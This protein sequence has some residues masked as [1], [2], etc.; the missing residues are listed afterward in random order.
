MA[1]R[2]RVRPPHSPSTIVAIEPPRPL[3]ARRAEAS[4]WATLL[5]VAAV[6]LATMDDRHVGMAADE[7]QMIWTAVAIAETGQ[8]AQ[9]R[10]R[11]FTFV[12][13]AGE[14]VSR[15]G[16]GMT[17]LQVPAAL[18]APAV[19]R[20]MGAGASQP[21]FLIVPF[22]LVLGGAAAAG[23]AC[24][25]LGGRASTAVLLASI[26]SPLASYAATG[27]S[28]PLQAAALTSAFALAL[29]SAASSDSG[30]SLRLAV[31]AGA[32][33][34][35]AVLAKSALVVVAPLVVVPVIVSVSDGCRARR[36]VAAV[37]GFLPPM[38]LWAV[39]D[40]ARF[41]SLL[42]AYPGETF[43]HPVWDGAW[44]LLVGPNQGLAWFFPA[45]LVV[46]WL[47]V[48]RFRAGERAALVPLGGALLPAAALFVLTASWWAWHGVWGWGPRLLMPAI[49]PLAAAAGAEMAAWPAWG[50]RAL[51]GLSIVLN[52]PGLV[53]HPTPVASYVSNLTWPVATPE[54]AR[55]L[56]GYAVRHESDGTVRVSPDHVLATM[57]QASPFVVFPWFFA[58]NWAD[59]AADAARSLESPP[60]SGAR[61]DLTPAERPLSEV[62]LRQITGFPRARFWGRGFAPTPADATRAAV[63]DE[64]LADQVVRCQQHGDG[65]NALRLAR[66]LA[67]LAPFGH[68]DALVLES[69]R[70]LGDRQSASDYL[71]QLPLERRAHPWINVVL[72]LYERD[73]GNDAMAAQF[74][75]SVL[76]RLSPDAPAQRA[77]TTPPASWPRGLQAMIATPVSVAG[78]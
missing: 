11:D 17:F 42:G 55:S 47:V 49:P 25:R 26:G 70:L 78:E 9:A 41:G 3:P 46:A 33:A 19:E 37:A 51:I 2:P 20:A 6:L 18:A 57:P 15:F 36:G 50:R 24:R 13:A 59:D 63:F 35:V 53:Q 43:N 27:F 58:A 16:L 29:A 74:L 40:W 67:G 34:G 12:T 8:W 7:R 52:L 30:R 45:S 72:A 77:V 76:P 64:G 68:N 65:P 71:R 75:S 56:A 48:R 14:A 44:R 54:F 4:L 28:E 69:Y 32:A 38:V 1:R 23:L 73:A 39:L 21:L 60:W 10:D 31:S 66:R 62:S 5:V 61:P 22:L